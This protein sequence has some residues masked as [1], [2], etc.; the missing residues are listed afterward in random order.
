[1]MPTFNSFTALAANLEAK[2]AA[3]V[4]DT[5]AAI[6]ASASDHSRVKTTSLK[7]GW[8]KVTSK[9]DGYDAAVAAAESV[10]PKVVIVSKADIT[11]KPTV[12]AVANV[13]AHAL[14]NEY[15]SSVEGE[16][17]MTAQPMLHPALDEARPAFGAGVAHLLDL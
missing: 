5:A 11:T 8:Y 4:D 9:V 12:A 14:P 10:N 16:A 2:A 1:M 6:V 3:L 17:R 7:V 15:G 13:T